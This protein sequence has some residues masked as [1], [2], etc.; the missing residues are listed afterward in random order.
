MAQP[1]AW[2]AWL[3]GSLARLEAAQLLRSLRP[4]LPT[5]SPVHVLV[6]P[7]TLASWLG[8]TV[9]AG[10]CSVAPGD[11]PPPVGPPAAPPPAAADAQAQDATRVRLFSSNDYLGLSAHPAVRAAYSRAAA[12]CGS[13]PRA[14]AL[15]AGYTHEHAAL[16]AQLAALKGTEACL[17]FPTGFAACSAAVQALG[18]GADSLLV[19]D[20]LNHASLV[21]GCRLARQAGASLAV[22]RHADAAHAAQLLGGAG[23]R[24][25]LITD[26]LFSMDGDLAPLGALGA[27]AR[28]AG[29][30]LLVD[31][32]HATLVYGEGG[33]GAVPGGMAPLA[34]VGTLSKAV[35]AQGG[36]VACSRALK[37]LLLSTARPAVYSTALPVPVVAAASAALTA[38]AAEPWRRDALWARVHQLRSLTGLACCVSPIV[39]FRLGSEAAALA[40]S[41]ALLRRGFHVPAIRP[42]TVPAGTARLRVAL[43]AAHSAEDVAALAAALEECGATAAARAAEAQ[44]GVMARL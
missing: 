11:P 20:A 42:P 25:L 29:A 16:E 15:V 30:A 8:G 37:Q 44:G 22:Y 18:A 34:H 31:D 27:A 9:S 33:A 40:A 4:V 3:A 2:D 24:K 23:G 38:A 26:S 39:P 13:G 43:S 14:S 7:D 5:E 21:D 19:A 12:L 28:A 6:P 1:P 10:A 41:A 36:F 32:A 17:L 35:G